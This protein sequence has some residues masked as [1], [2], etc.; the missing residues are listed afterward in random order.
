MA[1]QKNDIRTIVTLGFILVLALGFN[2][3]NSWMQKQVTR[4][5][6]SFVFRSAQITGRP[7]NKINPI[8]G[9]NTEV[10]KRTR[11]E[12]GADYTESVFF[13]GSQEVAK[14]RA[15]PDGRTETTGAIPDGKVK[16][17]N[18]IDQTYGEEYYLNGKKNGLAKT[19]FENGQPMAEAHYYAGRLMQNREYYANG[20]VRFEVDYSDARNEEDN[21]SYKNDKEAGVGRL[22]YENGNLKFEWRITKSDP[23]GY[24]RSYNQDGSLRAETLYDKYGSLIKK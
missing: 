18:D 10:T 15:W 12:R 4:D 23:E 22:Y 17:F 14:S 9:D 24:K 6:G 5:Q 20:A 3:L 8:L 7:G 13:I 11:I 1:K 21:F 16:F 19:F 2:L